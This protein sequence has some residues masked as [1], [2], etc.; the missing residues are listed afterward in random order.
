MALAR[1]RRRRARRGGEVAALSACRPPKAIDMP[2]R[3]TA[4]STDAQSLAR[5]LVDPI[6]APSPFWRHAC[7]R[8][9]ATFGRTWSRASTPPAAARR[10]RE[11]QRSFVGVTASS[12][13]R[14]EIQA[15][16][17]VVS[18]R[19]DPPGGTWFAC[20]ARRK[21]ARFDQYRVLQAR[22]DPRRECIGEPSRRSIGEMSC[23][24]HATKR[25]V[26]LSRC[27]GRCDCTRLA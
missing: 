15:H 1:T 12:M 7:E 10:G 25:P 9:A 8:R 26:S 18:V 20:V 11:R 22:T 5:Q 19:P 6:A 24:R 13:V 2:S 23:R 16:R 3:T 14:R 21:A 4:Q 17:Y 27:G